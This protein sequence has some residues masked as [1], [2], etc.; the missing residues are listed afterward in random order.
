LSLYWFSQIVSLDRGIQDAIQAMGRVR[1][2]VVLHIRGVLNPEVQAQL[3]LLA[4]NSGVKDRVIF[5]GLIPPDELLAT[6]VE[7]DVGLCL[8]IP[9]VLNREICITNKMFLYLL[10]GLTVVAS[11]T[12]GQSEVL[13]KCPEAGFL[14]DSGNIEQLALIIEQLARDPGL[15]A[16]ARDRWNWEQE[17]RTLVASI[18]NLLKP[19]SLIKRWEVVGASNCDPSQRIERD[20]Q[21][22]SDCE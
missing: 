13:A 16:A 14:Y 12:R 20:G 6:A 17:S 15:L 19:K 22:S 18:D 5:H 3:M 2:P 4:Q 21:A 1:E 11:R 9:A 7:H 8:E 10:A